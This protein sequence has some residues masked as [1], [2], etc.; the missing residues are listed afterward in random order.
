MVDE[1]RT[2]DSRVSP[3][4]PVLVLYS[5]RYWTGAAEPALTLARDLG[6]AGHSVRVA[7]D[8]LRA[9]NIA[10]RAQAL[11]LSLLDGVRCSSHAMPWQSLRD[12]WL[13]RRHLRTLRGAIVHC[14]LTHDH[15][16]GYGSLRGN[17]L[18]SHRLVRSIHLERSLGAGI[19]RRRLLRLTDGLIVGVR[20][21]RERLLQLHPLD[22][23]RVELIPAAVDAERFRASDAGVA[24]RSRHGIALGA[25]LV[26]MLARFQ[27]H[28]RHERLIE[29]F[30]EVRRHV[31]DALLALAG[32][33]EHEQALRQLAERRHE[34]GVVRFLGYVEADAL[35][36]AYNAADVV[37]WL[38]PGSDAG[39]RGML[40]ALACERAMVLGREGAM[41][42]VLDQSECAI[43]VDSR[44][45]AAIAEAIVTLLL[46]SPRRRAYGNAGRAHVLA[47]HAPATRLAVVRSFYDKILAPPPARG[48]RS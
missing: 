27:A 17:G 10:Q 12:I 13:L 36:A 14:H 28:R 32:R 39:C 48:G 40:E 41:N 37:V 25:P 46:D 47:R 2:G 5:Y 42:D 19:G 15:W 6:R 23:E 34:P 16:L 7:V 18:G 21:H 33:G 38:V 26:L 1:T 43:G 35:A 31:P 3:T 11:D 4:P 22:P 29:A 45:P 8:R 9:G 24:F 20:A 30:G 44:S